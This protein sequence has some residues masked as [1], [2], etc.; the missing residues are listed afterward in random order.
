MFRQDC[1][2]P[3]WECIFISGML[4]DI[5]EI[6]GSLFKQSK[7]KHILVI[8]CDTSGQVAIF[9]EQAS[10]SWSS[11]SV[12][13][14]LRMHWH[15][16]VFCMDMSCKTSPKQVYVL[17]GEGYFHVQ[18]PMQY[19]IGG[20]CGYLSIP[21]AFSPHHMKRKVPTNKK[22]FSQGLFF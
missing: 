2:K 17:L 22:M 16:L 20:F 15:S 12:G 5:P 9:P 3:S 8:W 13:V 10:V 1:T 4:W 14:L 19:L 6:W 11:T 7:W 18:D 21:S